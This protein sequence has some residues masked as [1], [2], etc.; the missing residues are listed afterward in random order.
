MQFEW[1]E[2]KN[3]ANITK[4]GIGFEIAKDVF[5]DKNKIIAPNR[6]VDKEERFQVIGE[7]EGVIVIMVVFTPRDGKV[8]IIS[9][10]RANKKERTNYENQTRT[11]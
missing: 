2:N 7:I 9:A 1:D 3:K 6:I 10:R 5:D 11:N 4:H 8:R